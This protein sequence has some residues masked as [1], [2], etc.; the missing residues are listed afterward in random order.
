MRTS[1]LAVII[2][3]FLFGCAQSN[4]TPVQPVSDA[5]PTVSEAAVREAEPLSV[6]NHVLSLEDGTYEIRVSY[7]SFGLSAIDDALAQFAQKAFDESQDALQH[8]QASADMP[9]G[10]ILSYHFDYVIVR[11]TSSA[12]DLYYEI[13]SHQG[14]AHPSF[15]YQTFMFDPP[16]GTPRMPLSIFEGDAQHTLETLSALSRERLQDA[17]KAHDPEAVDDAFLEEM[18]MDGTTPDADHFQHIVRTAD[19]FKILFEPYAVAPWAHGPQTIDVT[20]A[21]WKASH[22]H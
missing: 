16:E 4:P 3:L 1:L 15:A 13:S 18:R 7:P 12:I 8:V 9:P 11:A 2:S 19:G 17:L 20:W 21:D 5:A 14:G 6:E 22:K 10:A